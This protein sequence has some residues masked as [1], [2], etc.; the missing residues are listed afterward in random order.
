MKVTGVKQV[1]SNINR[2]MVGLKAET[3]EARKDALEVLRDYAIQNVQN[4]SKSQTLSLGDHPIRSKD[5]WEVID[6]GDS[7]ELVCNSEHAAIVEFG[8]EIATQIKY[9]SMNH[10]GYR[11]WPILSEGGLSNVAQY[12]RTFTIQRPMSYFRSAINSEM[13]RNAML[14]AIRNKI[15]GRLN[16]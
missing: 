9:D 11:G 15:K 13:V 2:L 16:I 4:L 7:S 14:Q 10:K 12:R 8:T 6:R 5:S 3:P 1:Q